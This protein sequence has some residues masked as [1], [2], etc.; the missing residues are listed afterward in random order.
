MAP[1]T[2]DQQITFIYVDDL[3]RSAQ[4]YETVMGFDL[5]LDQ[6]SCRIYHVHGTAY[7]GICQISDDSK[8]QRDSVQ[9][10]I[11]TLVTDDVDG[12]HTYLKNNGVTFDHPPQ[13][14]PKYKIYHCFLRDPD[15]YLIEIQRF[16]STD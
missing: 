9:N 4:F 7:L 6:G 1:P 16:L 14:N 10:L 12:W 2:I 15:G 3:T 11:F 5:W 13:K 8:G